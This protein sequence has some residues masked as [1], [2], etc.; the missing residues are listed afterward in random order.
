[1][2]KKACDCFAETC[3]QQQDFWLPKIRLCTCLCEPVFIFYSNFLLSQ[4]FASFFFLA[5][6]GKKKKKSVWSRHTWLSSLWKAPCLFLPWEQLPFIF[7]DQTTNKTSHE[8]VQRRKS[9]PGCFS[10]RFQQTE[11][12]GFSILYIYT[13]THVFWNMLGL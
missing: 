2:G 9:I 11:F 8:A 5:F 10:L 7:S 12:W 3:M 4:E 13:H 6:L 1:M